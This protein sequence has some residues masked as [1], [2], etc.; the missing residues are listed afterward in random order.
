MNIQQHD[1][2]FRASYDQSVP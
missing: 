2:L 1:S